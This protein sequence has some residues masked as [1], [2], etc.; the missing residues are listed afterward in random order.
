MIGQRGIA[1][2]EFAL[3]VPVLLVLLAGGVDIGFRIWARAALVDAVAQGAMYAFLTGPSV[4][5]SAVAG[6]VEQAAA[7]PGV[8]ATVSGPSSGC[9]AAGSPTLTAAASNGTCADGTKPGT[10]LTIAAS[11]TAFSLSTTLWSEPGV[12]VSDQAMV[13]LQ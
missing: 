13:R 7:I 5:A 9:L 1:A 4:T 8:S 3:V 11:A 12:S 10:F 2:V 6:F